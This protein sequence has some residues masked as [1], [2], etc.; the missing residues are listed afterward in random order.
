MTSNG[1]NIDM[2]LLI[3]KLSGNSK[4]ISRSLENLLSIKY[5]KHVWSLSNR[6]L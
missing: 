1:G 4:E 2:V 5:T 6:V 3:S